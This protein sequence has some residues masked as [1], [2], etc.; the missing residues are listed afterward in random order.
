[1]DI[2]GWKYFKNW[3]FFDCRIG[4]DWNYWM[5]CMLR[6]LSSKSWNI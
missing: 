1:M 2:L 3:W 5:N 4:L 6:Y